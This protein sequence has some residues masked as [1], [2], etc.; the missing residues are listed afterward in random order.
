MDDPSGWSL[1]ESDPQVFSELLRELGVTGLQVDDL[2][3]LDESTLATLRPIHALIFLFKWVGGAGAGESVGVEID[4][5]EGGVWFANQVINNSCATV[6]ALNAVMNIPS[7]VSPHAGESIDIG[8][9]LA[10]LRDFGAG[11][12][13][14]DLGHVV[15]SSDRIREVHNSFSK[16][17]PFSLDPS[18][19]PER[20]KEDA[21]HFVAY[22]PVNGV[23]YE[24][25]GLRAAPIMHAAVE[26]DWLD[27][28]R[29]TIEARIA[30]Y[31]PGSVMFNLLAI[32]SAAVPRLQRQI[33][34]PATP[35]HERLALQDQLDHE[36]QKASQGAVENSLRRHNM[37][38]LVLGLL[39]A[40]HGSKIKTEVIDAA[41]TKG[42]ERRDKAK[43]KKES[44]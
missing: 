19:V 2:Y 27:Q 17:S 16:T 31:P 36:S 8:P 26:G 4:P 29:E 18:L 25:D 37:L 23:L 42:K 43:A 11:M 7:Q 20:E 5:L 6:A 13:S 10:N 41:R 44:E 35:A 1:T 38:P 15:A 12:G 3:T 34:D 9:E 21:Y 39:E 33:A 32:R 28:A 14:M 30:T 40:L 22:L 24:L